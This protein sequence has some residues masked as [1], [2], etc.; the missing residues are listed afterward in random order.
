MGDELDRGLDTII[1]DQR[2]FSGMKP[3][4]LL[5]AVLSSSMHGIAQDSPEKTMIYNLTL[6]TLLKPDYYSVNITVSEY[7]QYQ[8]LSKKEV[9]A[10]IVS[11]DTLSKGLILHISN[12]G[13]TQNLHK[14]S[15][16][17][18]D[19][20]DYYARR[21]DKKLF[22]V[23]YSF[24]LYNK[25]SV[26]YLFSNIDK[27]IVSGMRISPGIL[28]ATVEKVKQFLIPRGMKTTDEYAAEIAKKM[29]QKIIKSKYNIVFYDGGV[30]RNNYNDYNKKFFIDFEDI[31]YK[32][33]VSY[34][35]SFAEK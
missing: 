1:Y 8:R 25:D 11:I 17:E 29:D 6:D 7:V 32:L 35:Y 34:S 31:Q 26:D 18:I 2:R 30:N 27:T 3:T 23:T 12:L 16:T 24:R 14:S 13:F 10:N 21:S 19:Q 4:I 15:I 22:Q 9:R 20:N 28:D 33:T 5:L